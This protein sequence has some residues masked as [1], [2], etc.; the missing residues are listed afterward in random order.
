MFGSKKKKASSSNDAGSRLF[1]WLGNLAVFYVTLLALISIPFLVLALILF[2]R[3]VMD[4]HVWI[5]AGITAITAVTLVFLIRRRKQIREQFEAEKKD[6]M[7]IIRSAARE[8]H[9]V[10]I[11]FMRGLI[12]LDYRGS[13]NEGRLLEGSKLSQL[14]ALTLSTSGNESEEIMLD[15]SKDLSETQTPGIASELEKLSGL[16]EKGLLTEAEYQELKTRLIDH[17]LSNL[18]LY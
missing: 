4:Y 18:N 5:L 8:G 6:V 17:K 2:F 12:S 10:N 16:L 14:K 3:T 15:N 1:S 13:N 11:S 7:E 9:N